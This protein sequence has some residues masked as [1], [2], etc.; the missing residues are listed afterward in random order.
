MGALFAADTLQGPKVDWYAI[1]PLLVLLGGAM[2]L[3]VVGALTPAWPKRCYALYTA[4]VAAGAGVM[5]VTLWHRIDDKGTATLI[6]DALSLD[7]TGVWLGLTI[8]V[9]VF[10]AAFL[11]DDYLRREGLDGL[12]LYVLYLLA[13]LGGL[14]MAAANDLVVLFLG[15][16]I[17]S[18]ALYVM[19]ASH[20]KRIKSQESGIKYFVLGGFSSAFFLYGIALVY[21]GAGST[22]FSKIVAGFDATIQ[23]PGNDALTLAGIALLLVGLAFK[24][25]AVPFHFWSPDV[26]EGAPTPVTAFMASAGKAAAFGAMLRV[27]GALPQWSDDYRPIVW[28]LGVLTLVGGAVMAVVQRNVKRMLAFSSISHAGFILVGVEAAVHF[29]GATLQRDGVS[30]VLVYLLV[31]AV[32]VMGTF[33]VVTAV[34]RTGDAATGLDGFR[35]LAKQQPMLALGMT[36]LL[37]AQAGVPLTSGFVAKFGVITA[38]VEVRSYAIAIIA[39]VSAVIAAFLYLRIMISMWISEPEAGDDAR[40]PVRI[41]LLL[42]VAVALSVA[43]TLVIGFFPDILLTIAP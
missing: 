5:Q 13:A 38:A 18:I 22:N 12:E 11:T 3:L 29:D 7:K 36:V 4:A 16:E 1:S 14:V 15:L 31:Y 24:V 40:E 21:G 37:L 27:L 42:G 20:R 19:A 32:L 9:A 6:G 35:G 28:T 8:C 17:L 26:Y 10:L 33:G 34:G 30:S 2:V 23:E 25:A 41:P 39:M 43:F